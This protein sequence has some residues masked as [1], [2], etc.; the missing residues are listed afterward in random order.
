[1]REGGRED[2]TF[3]TLPLHSRHPPICSAAGPQTGK[4][5]N[6]GCITEKGTK[7]R[8]LGGSLS[9]G[10]RKEEDILVPGNQYINSVT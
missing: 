7:G 2:G 6:F 10:N 9:V 1:M 3:E 5:L 8:G 4:D